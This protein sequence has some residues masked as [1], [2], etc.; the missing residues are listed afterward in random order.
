MASDACL[1]TVDTQPARGYS[2]EREEILDKVS[3]FV[4]KWLEAMGLD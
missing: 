4:K 1:T 2:F 3:S